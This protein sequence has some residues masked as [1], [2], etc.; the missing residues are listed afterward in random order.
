MGLCSEEARLP[1]SPTSDAV[2]PLIDRA[3]ADAG[4]G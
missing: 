3:M 2:K 1:L 4:V